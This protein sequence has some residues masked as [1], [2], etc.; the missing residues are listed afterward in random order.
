MLATML[1]LSAVVLPGTALAAPP[2]PSTA[3]LGDLAEDLLPLENA[4][5]LADDARTRITAGVEPVVTEAARAKVATRMS[6][7]EDRR[8]AREAA[9]ARFDT[10]TTSVRVESVQGSGTSRTAEIEETSG[11]PVAGTKD[12]SSSTW[13]HRVSYEWT[14]GRWAIAD[15]TALD[16]NSVV[17]D[18]RIAASA[19]ES[20]EQRRAAIVDRISTINQG[21]QRNLPAL[22][23]GDQAKLA[24]KQV[25]TLDAN[26]PAGGGKDVAAPSAL[27]RTAD[28]PMVAVPHEQVGAQGGE[29]PPYDYRFMVDVAVYYARD[30]AVPYV[31]DTND[32]TTFISWV[33]WNGRYA[34][35]GSESL[36]DAIW[37]YDDYDVWYYRCNDCSPRKTYTWGGARN[38]N[39]Y[40]NN[41]GN[42]VTFLPYLSDLLIS[43]VFQM[44]FNGYGDPPNIPDHTT[45]VTGRGEDGWPLLSYHSN[46]ERNK[47]MWDTIGSEDGPFW[48]IRT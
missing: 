22:K 9:G 10:V 37:N 7:S 43:D 11:H 26:P 21:I 34:E 6:L 4:A 1:C 35:A 19:R 3:E 5:V 14:E 24:G 36:I 25:E 48:A 29:G 31:R 18:A 42:R 2:E 33:L 30:N 15:I 13:R 17:S 12:G 16:R 23:A 8:F 41:Y 44:D 27:G 45:M 39:I 20:T 47:A 32:C 38:W 46:D 28:Q 40:E